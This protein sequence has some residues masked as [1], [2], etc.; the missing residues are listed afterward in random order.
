MTKLVWMSDLHF[1]QE[2]TVLGHDPRARLRTAIDH[3]N[4]HHTDASLC[5]ISGDMVHRGTARDYAALRSE[6]DRLAM[7]YAPMMG[8]HDTRELLRAALPLPDACMEGF[9]QYE[10]ETADGLILCLD[11][12]RSGSDAGEFC[13]D[14]RAW[15]RTRLEDAGNRPAYLFLHH[16]PMDLGLPAQDTEKMTY[17]AAFLDL[18]EDHR[19]TRHLFIGHVHRTVTGSVRG[20][21]FTTMRSVL[22][23]APP[24]SPPWDWSN[25]TPGKEAPCIGVVFLSGGDVTIQIEEISQQPN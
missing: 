20:I 18:V 3:I 24:P 7:P 17:G 22:F 25:F 23:Q 15:L 9:V 12:H 16:P 1:A 19:A 4:A 14:R 6:L 5:V 21:P 8:N 10:I 11:T 2:G 13:A